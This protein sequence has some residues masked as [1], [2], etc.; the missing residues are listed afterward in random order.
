MQYD[1]WLSRGLSQCLTIETSLIFKMF[2]KFLI[3]Q[4]CLF[5]LSKKY[6]NSRSLSYLQKR[7]CSFF[8]RVYS[9]MYSDCTVIVTRQWYQW[10]PKH[11]MNLLTLLPTIRDKGPY[12]WIEQL[13]VR[14]LENECNFVDLSLSNSHNNLRL[15]VNWITMW[16]LNYAFEHIWYQI[17]FRQALIYIAQTHSHMSHQINVSSWP[18]ARAVEPNASST[19][20]FIMIKRVH[21]TVWSHIS[22]I[23][24][25]LKNLRR[26]A[27]TKQF[28]VAFLSHIYV[29]IM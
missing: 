5:A 8:E 25:E 17:S 4:L 10:I 11:K 26:F 23:T 16:R 14:R 18:N 15:R 2:T 12:G 1:D 24:F 27:N 22:F 19:V 6:I 28:V 20:L 21:C 13:N 3:N 7:K 29:C 9:K